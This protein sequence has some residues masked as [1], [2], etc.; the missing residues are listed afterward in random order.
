MVLEQVCV[1][2]VYSH[3]CINIF[4]VIPLVAENMDYSAVN[5]LTVVFVAGSTVSGAAAC[6]NVTI[7]D[8][9]ALESNHF[10]TVTVNGLELDPGAAYSGL[11]FG[12]PSS[13][14]INIIDNEGNTKKL[15]LTPNYAC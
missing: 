15:L 4:L 10:F 14:P 7:I 2:I 8:D 3:V 9:S 13:V 11:M 5:P 6:T 1:S 12:M